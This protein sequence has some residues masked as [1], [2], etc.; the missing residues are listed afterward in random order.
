[1]F[2]N[3]QNVNFFNFDFFFV[4]LPNQNEATVLNILIY[5]TML[6]LAKNFRPFTFRPS[7]LNSFFCC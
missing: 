6:F 5:N 4:S 7:D 1:V 2:W 3:R